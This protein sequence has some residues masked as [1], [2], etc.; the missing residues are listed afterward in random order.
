MHLG[1]GGPRVGELDEEMVHESRRGDTFLLGATT[2][3]IDE[4]TRDRV[5]VS[6]APGEPGKMP[7]WR[8]EG[9][10]RPIELG[11]AVGALT[12]EIDA[13]LTARGSAAT[14]TELR[15]RYPLDAFAADNLVAYVERQREV[16]GAVPTDETIVI[17]RFRDELGDWRVC[18]LTPLGAWVHAPWALVIGR[19]LEDRLGYPV[20]ALATDDGI[21]LR[22]TDG[23]ELPALAELIPGL[24]ELDERLLA[25]VARSTRFAGLF[26]RVRRARR[27]CRAG[28]PAC[29]RRC[30]SS[31]RRRSSC[32]AWRCATRRSRSC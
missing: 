10:G 30:G 27:Y 4:I 16:A 9:P 18:I 1:E 3:R 11:R 12:W 28:A 21:A 13:A 32:S 29:A 14:V 22:L 23:D 20:H 19:R 2:W 17:E 25:E 7:F 15:A 26:W 5:L 24:A 31:G 6:P 8:G